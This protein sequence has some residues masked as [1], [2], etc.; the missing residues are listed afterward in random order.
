MIDRDSLPPI[1]LAAAYF[2]GDYVINE[3]FR[4]SQP[5]VQEIIAYGEKEYWR[6]V[7]CVTILSCD[8]MSE[9]ADAGKYW[10]DVPDFEMFYLMLR[11]LPPEKTSILF[12]DKLDFRK[13]GWYRDTE[14][15]V[16]CM[17]D[18]ENRIKIDEYLYAKMYNYVCAIH[19]IIKKPVYAGNEITRQFMVD[20][21]RLKKQRSKTGVYKSTLFPLSSYLTSSTNRTLQ[22]IGQMK[23]FAFLDTI[24]RT[25][26]ISTSDHILS[27]I[28]AGKV[29]GDKVNK[30]VLDSMR[31]LYAK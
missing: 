11:D 3:Q 6:L 31:D 14:L 25:N 17:V 8:M 27:G 16:Y 12:G 13:F 19:G 22:D 2:G 1:D 7:N 28:Y 15:N 24:K 9:L 4:I 18:V 5:T 30:K 23:I 10:G 29:D 20:D 21:D 26:A